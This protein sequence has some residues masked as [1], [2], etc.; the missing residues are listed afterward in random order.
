ME[1]HTTDKMGR[2][3]RFRFPPGRILS[4]VPSITELLFDLGLEE[5]IVGRTKFCTHP[6]DK[7]RSLPRVGGTKALKPEIIRELRPDLILANQEEN[8]RRQILKIAHE[9][10]VWVSD[11]RTFDDALFFIMETGRLT[12]AEQRANALA[13]RIRAS[14]DA[15]PELKQPVEVLYLIWKNPLMAVGNSTFIHSMLEICGLRNCLED[16]QRYPALEPGQIQSLNPDYVFLSSEPFPFSDKHLEDL[17][18][19]FPGTRFKF[20]DGRYFS[21]YGSAMLGAAN[22]FGD[23]IRELNDEDR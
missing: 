13:D 23:L 16:I 17:R 20:V 4:V 2:S 19:I 5:R 1:I 15:L 14:F 10:P 12:D 3:V 6:P 7:V 11:V 22:Y 9:F 21:W 18:P 8:T